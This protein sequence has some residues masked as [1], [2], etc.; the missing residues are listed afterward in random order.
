MIRQKVRT[1]S[2]MPTTGHSTGT[3]VFDLALLWSGGLV[4]DGCVHAARQFGRLLLHILRGP[5]QR[6][7]AR[8]SHKEVRTVPVFNAFA[9]GSY[10]PVS[11]CHLFRKMRMSVS[12]GTVVVSSWYFVISP[13]Y[14][15]IS[16]L[17][18][19]LTKQPGADDTHI[20][21]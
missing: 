13:Q 8:R 11:F 17:L 6:H 20:K 10:R 18:F 4:P 1:R 19:C 7:L 3:R 21:E 2:R 16:M 12:F 14:H 9:V 15:G 5:A